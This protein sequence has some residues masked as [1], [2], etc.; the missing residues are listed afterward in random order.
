MITHV[1][2][3]A[4]GAGGLAVY[5][6]FI[7]CLVRAAVLSS[8]AVAAIDVAVATVAVTVT[9]TI[10]ITDLIAGSTVDHH[11]ENGNLECLQHIVG[12]VEVVAPGAGD[13]DDEDD[14]VDDG[15]ED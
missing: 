7:R 8:W 13:P 2:V 3:P 5:R 1:P 12:D 10:T 9:M 11:A 4:A 6:R 14:A 15:C